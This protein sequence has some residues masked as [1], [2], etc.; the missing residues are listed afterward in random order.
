MHQ[1]AIRCHPF[2]PVATEEVEAWLEAE[3]ER[4]REQ[5]PHATLRLLRLA[6]TLPTGDADVGWLIEIDPA[7]GEPPLDHDGLA[8]IVRDLR[9]LGL[10]PTL[11]QAGLMLGSDFAVNGA[12]SR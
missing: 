10:Q 8:R 5:A 1:L 2:T 9:L 11:F 4:L 7:G 12:V 6:Q 3:V